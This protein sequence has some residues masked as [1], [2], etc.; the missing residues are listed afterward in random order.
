MSLGMNGDELKDHFEK[1]YLQA[2]ASRY[3]NEYPK[4]ERN[5][6]AQGISQNEA[7][8]L[9]LSEIQSVSIAQAVV[10]VIQM[11]NVWIESQ[12]KEKGINL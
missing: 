3:K 10:K 2:Y 7:K 12:L 4:I 6:A 11:N 1:E 5:F 8:L 9:A